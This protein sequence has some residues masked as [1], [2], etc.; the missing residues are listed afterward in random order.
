MSNKQIHRNARVL[1]L[2]QPESPFPFADR[3]L[4]LISQ[5]RVLRL[6]SASKP[7]IQQ[8]SKWE[9]NLS[10]KITEVATCFKSVNQDYRNSNDLHGGDGQS[11]QEK[12]GRER[13]ISCMVWER[14][15]C[16]GGRRRRLLFSGG[17]RL[18]SPPLPLPE[19]SLSFF[20]FLRWE[21]LSPSPKRRVVAS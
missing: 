5:S 18:A 9:S 13:E 10:I 6:G 15:R 12:P 16:C 19:T 11:K 2:G 17:R 20:F 14:R 4:S 3:G 1:R 21:P 7:L 8:K